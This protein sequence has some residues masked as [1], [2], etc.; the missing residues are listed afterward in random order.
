MKKTS[1]IIVTVVAV[2]AFYFLFLFNVIARE[3][4]GY[5]T[6]GILGTILLVAL[7]GSLAAI[8]KKADDK[9]G[10]DSDIQK[11]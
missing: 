4:A 7:V 2:I 10:N 9:G 5:S 1:K 6:P 8:W 11:K 3:D